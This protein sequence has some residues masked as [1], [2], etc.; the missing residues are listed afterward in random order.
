[1]A[2]Q[3]S[4]LRGFRRIL[5]TSTALVGIT[6]V[7]KVLD[8]SQAAAQ[9]TGG[10]GGAGVTGVAGTGGG[11]DA[12]GNPIGGGA[13]TGNSGGGGG[14]SGGGAGGLG[15]T[16]TGA[17]GLDGAG[18]TGGAGGANVLGGSTFLLFNGETRTGGNGV[19]GTGGQNGANGSSGTDNGGGGGGGG[20]GGAGGSG[21]TVAGAGNDGS[22]GGTLSGGGGGAGGAG[23]AGGGV[24]NTFDQ[25]R[26]AGSGGQG[27]AGGQGGTGAYFIGPGANFANANG[28]FVLGGAGG[29]GGT[30]GNGAS[31]D[32]ITMSTPGAGGN[33]GNGGAGGDAVRFLNAAATFR[34]N[35]TVLGGGGGARGNGGAGGS[36][37]FPL[38]PAGAGGVDGAV[39][40]G[41]SGVV[42]LGATAF[43]DNFGSIGG[44]IGG[45]GGSGGQ[46]VSVLGNNARLNNGAIIVGGSGGGGGT[47]G[48]AG[49]SGAAAVSFDGAGATF[50]NLAASTLTGGNGGAGAAGDNGSGGFPFFTAAGAGGSGGA[51]GAAALFAG[52]N[53]TFTNRGTVT[54]GNGGSGGSGGS[55][56]FSG[57]AGGAGGAGGA[58][59][60]FTGPAAVF[61]NAATITGGTGGAGGSGGI[62]AGGFIG[63]AGGA[64]GA[65][66]AGVTFT[67]PG[68]IFTNTGTVTGGTGGLGAASVGAIPG[69]A[70]ANG[71]GGVG[72]IGADL[73]IINAGTIAGGLAGGGG[74]ADAINCTSGA[75][76]LELRAATLGGVYSGITGNAVVLGGTGT[77]ALGG[78]LDK[79]FDVSTIGSKYLGFTTFEKT[80]PS[81]WTLTGT[82]ASV[83]PWVIGEGTL[84]ISADEN[85]GDASGG[86]TFTGG[87]LGTTASFTSARAI[88]LNTAGTVQ[89]DA[90]VITTLSGVIADGAGGA[91][92]LTKSGAGTL[93][94]SGANTYTGTTTINGGTLRA[95]AA[96]VIATSS[97][98]ALNAGTFD[99]NNLNQSVGP[100]SGGSGTITLG[101][102]TLT[103]R[104]GGTAFSGAI[105]GPGN[106]VVQ[107]GGNQFTLAG[108]NTYSGTTTVSDDASG[109]ALLFVS[110]SIR[111]SKTILVESNTSAALLAVGNGGGIAEDTNIT[112]S[113]TARPI[114]R[115][116]QSRQIG[117]L[118]SSAAGAIIDFA[119]GTTL[120][121]GT[122]NGND[123]FVGQISFDGNGALTKVGTGTFTLTGANLYLGDTTISGGTLRIGDGTAAGNAGRLG[124]DS[125]GTVFSNV[126]T[127]P[128]GTLAFAR[129]DTYT[130]GGT[131]TGAGTVEQTGSGTT[132]LTGT[133]GPGSG[134]TGT[135]AV[136]GGT[137][138]IDGVLGDVTGNAAR[139]TVGTDGR[140]V[141]GG[142]FAGDVTNNGT[143]AAGGA[144]GLGSVGTLRIGGSY[145]IAAGSTNAF[146]LGT[147]NIAAG[148]A[149][150]DRI[151]VGGNLTIGGGT[152]AL[153]NIAASGLYRLYDVGGIVTSAGA[154]NAG[155][156]AVTASNGTATVYTLP[157]TGAPGPSQVNARIAI[158]GQIVQFWDGTDLTGGTAGAQGG[159]GVWNAT[160]A[161]WTD[162][163][164]AGTVNQPW[165][166]QVGVFTAPGA[167]GASTVTLVGQQTIQTLQFAG[168]GYTLVAGAGGT[169]NLTGDPFGLAGFSTLRVDAGLSATIA[170]PITGAGLNKAVGSGNLILT[171]SNSFSA[172]NV[173]DGTVEVR[174]G[175]AILDT[176]A[177]TLGNVAG[178]RLFVTNSE[179]IG[180]LAGGGSAGG[181]VGI[182]A[183]QALTTGGTGTATTFA[184]T[185]DGAGSLVKT[186]AGTFTL[187]GASTYNGGTTINAGTL[188]IGDGGTTGTIVG[189]VVNNAA[190]GFNRS[191]A[192]TFAGT[193]SGS[194]RVQQTGAGTTTLTGVNTYTGGT[195]ISAGTL[196]GASTSFGTGAIVDNAALVL[197]QPID[198]SFANALGGTGSLTK[199]GA[200][201]LTYTGTGTLSGPTQVLGGGL[202]VNGSLA[203]SAV[204]VADGALVGGTGTVG[205]LVIGAGGSVA[206]GVS[207]APGSLGTLNVAGSVSFA[208]G[209][210]YRVDATKAGAADRIS[211]TG[212]ATLAGGTVQ[213]T[214]GQGSYDNRTRY[215]I[216]SA[217]GGVSGGFSGVTANF[218]FLSPTL[219]YDPTNVYLTL[220][221]NAVAFP[222]VAGTRNQANVAGAVQAG[223]PGSA[224]YD[225][226]LRLT[227]SQAQAAFDALSGELHASAVSGQFTTAALIREAIL[228]RLRFGETGFGGFGA[229]GIGQRFAPGTT[230]PAMYTADL[231]GRKVAPVLVPTQFVPPSPVAVWGTGFG[232]FG[233]IGGT[234]NAGRLDTQ[235][236]GFVLGADTRLDGTWRVGVAGGYTFNALDL[237]ARASHATVES[238]FGAVYAGA[239][240]GP[241]QLR[242]GGSYAGNSLATSRAVLF[243]GFSQSVS[244]RYGGQVGQAFGEV[245]YRFG[246][247]ECYLEPFVGAAGIRIGQDGF[248]ERGGVAALSGAAQ[249]YDL[250]TTTVGLQ[251]SSVLGSLFGTDAPLSV[252][253]L[254]G[255]RRAYG[256]VVPS[257][258]F[259][260]AATGQSFVAAGVPIA[261]DALVAQAGLDWQFSRA[262][263]FSLNYTGQVGTDRTQVHGVKG[264]FVYR[265]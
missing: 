13:G 52:A 228:D 232:S 57:A 177:V 257:S 220:G 129:T 157:S 27:G 213:V 36:T 255:Y 248:T 107:G 87:T 117:S 86:I 238:G 226:I 35:G 146:D 102:A 250:A 125:S 230:L 139:L 118:N 260:F 76:R 233:S 133:N 58:G 96:D 10:N 89:T 208:A 132:I 175:A 263:T 7:A 249:R 98:L 106:L 29:S 48:R 59:V 179:T 73:T 154:A 5:L 1:M 184:G 262:T 131:I 39:G 234:A 12:G 4:V 19:S 166:S 64:G 185:I 40:A 153:T 101:T 81:I 190:L 172:L 159:S 170:A 100:I 44:G 122:N 243:P 18:G 214:A 121:T 9:A 70:G 47:T 3:S 138:G 158:G 176:A 258:L 187:T 194:G 204:S 186:G 150:N 134:F 119:S 55:D 163:P 62:G 141:G 11:V 104:A 21:A 69:A 63:A 114:L 253:G 88:T 6:L 25:G 145:T 147:P 112:L 207:A 130:Y 28:A 49:G 224:L 205:G 215:T 22:N 181:A 94:L 72:V 67:G 219:S 46:G 198:A 244:A 77:L 189:N 97:G 79:T 164:V 126:L 222:D 103:T 235:T 90:G 193:I 143:V 168:D 229:D 152:L 2:N 231:P 142:T 161:N 246:T 78:P 144:P 239:N 236:S 149:G 256:D 31:V 171:G 123:T 216:L 32:F 74:Q 188:Q 264:G 237:N 137:L 252:R 30:G 200:G 82:T 8:P 254:L 201:I 110:G 26:Q 192:Y 174:G 202:I 206:P 212:T 196:V 115:L 24:A 183:G 265:W 227:G 41:G 93:V 162:D 109:F 23:G 124:Q 199:Q 203:G 61:T 16:A 240:F 225:A 20:G 65:G 34:N 148:G 241:A 83:T 169:L 116:L 155:F 140:L 95:G 247:A 68:G 218:A 209:S 17:N 84:S 43:L 42:F 113:G 38:F 156:D 180:S 221:R 50:F 15:G 197:D 120:T 85:L 245:G 127:G 99:L 259:T 173:A 195:L 167:G 75:N 37:N 53:A 217:T 242:F 191:N 211:A 111:N 261:R 14:G 178:V 105:T 54:G 92:S 91:G 33:G 136:T 251:G 60:S 182:A 66:G 165:Q 51:G 128:L 71:A 210:F 56:N 80:G 223:G 45:A 151:A 108:T 135:V 160:N